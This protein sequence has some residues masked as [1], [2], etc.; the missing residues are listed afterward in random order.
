MELTQLKYFK[1]VA[2]KE[3]LTKAAQE[4]HTSQPALSKS[5]KSLES[6]L[7]FS[8][9]DRINKHLK[10]NAYG[11]IVLHHTRHIFQELSDMSASLE[12]QKLNV[13]LDRIK[14]I[15]PSVDSIRF[16]KYLVLKNEL[17]IHISSKNVMQKDL[18]PL[19]LDDSADVAVSLEPISHP[20]ITCTEFGKENLA[21]IVPSDHPLAIQD[22]V[23]LKDLH[24][25]KLLYFLDDRDIYL[26]NFFFQSLQAQGIQPDFIFEIDQKMFDYLKRTQH[27]PWLTTTFGLFEDE[28]Q[29]DEK[30]LLF[31]RDSA[32]QASFYLVYKRRENPNLSSFLQWIRN[33]AD[34]LSD[35]PN[36]IRLMD[37]QRSG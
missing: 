4:L 30:L 19:L 25:L 37:E 27:S 6:E 10:L 29:P 33:N 16:F 24:R 35:N 17:S 32:M 5:L 21:L 11:E 15:S 31:D 23:S 26:D 28:I 9:F 13:S 18:L 2:E 34:A 8:L 7:G 12:K 3:S 1:K 36:Y 14:L 22:T 20:D